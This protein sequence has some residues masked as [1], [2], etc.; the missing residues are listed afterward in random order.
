M[1]KEEELFQLSEKLEKILHSL[2]FDRFRYILICNAIPGEHRDNS[3]LGFLA[4]VPWTAV[5]D[6]DSN[7]ET[8]GM[9]DLMLRNSSCE[10]GVTGGVFSKQVSLHNVEDF[11]NQSNIRNM[12]YSNCGTCWI[13]ANGRKDVSLAQ[14]TFS[15]WVANCKKPAE[16]ALYA[17]MHVQTPLVSVYLLLS[18][19]SLQELASLLQFNFSILGLR[20]SRKGIALICEDGAIVQELRALARVDIGEC[21]VAGMSWTCVKDSIRQMLMGRNLF[22]LSTEKHVVSSSGSPVTVPLG[23]MR[24]WEDINVVGYYEC[25]GEAENAFAEMERSRDNFYKGE[26]PE[27]LNFYLRHDIDRYLLRKLKEEVQQ[28]LESLKGQTLGQ[29]RENKTSIRTVVL[30]HSPGTGGTTLC[31]RV[32]WEFR[33]TFRCALIK[34]ITN[35]TAMQVSSLYDCK[36]S[37][38]GPNAILP[39]LLLVDCVDVLS[40][41]SFCSDLNRSRVRSV[42]L[43]CRPTLYEPPRKKRIYGDAE[44]R[45]DCHLSKSEIKQVANLINQLEPDRDKGTQIIRNV[46]S[47]KQILYFGLQL[48]GQEYNRKL[49]EKYVVYH[50]ENVAELEVEMLKFCSLVYTYMHVGIPRPC[51]QSL[52]SSFEG[53]FRVSMADISDTT[54]DMIV[55]NTEGYETYG[56]E[57]YRPAHHLIGVEVLHRFSLFDTAMQFLD[58]MVG[59]HSEFANVEILTSIAIRLFTKRDTK[60]GWDEENVDGDEDIAAENASEHAGLVQL[61]RFSPLITTLMKDEG[62]FEALELLLVLCQKTLQR[63]GNAF[64][65]QHLAR[66]LAYEVGEMELPRKFA[67]FLSSLLSGETCWSHSASDDDDSNFEMSI[68]KYTGYEAAVMAINKAIDQDK[69]RSTFHTTKGLVYKLQLSP[70]KARRCSVER[71]YEVIRTAQ[72]SLEAFEVAKNCPMSFINWYTMIGKIEVCLDLLAIVK[73][74]EV[75]DNCVSLADHKKVFREF[76]DRLDTPKEMRSLDPDQIAFIRGREE[77]IRSTLDDIFECEHLHLTARWDK[78]QRYA[79]QKKSAQARGAILRR[80]FVEVS[81]CQYAIYLAK[82]ERKMEASPE[83]RRQMVDEMLYTQGEDPYST[84]VGFTDKDMSEIVRWLKPSCSLQEGRLNTDTETTV[85]MFVRACVEGRDSSTLNVGTNELIAIVNSW[86]SSK[87]KSAWAHLFQY[88]LYFPLPN[89]ICPPNKEVVK[90]AINCCLTTIRNKQYAPRKSRPRYFVGRGEGIA[91]IMPASR[92]SLE[93][94]ENT[95]NFWRSKRVM[96]SL[97]RLKGTKHKFGQIMYQ[98]IEVSFD[99]ELY[100]KESKDWLWFYLGFTIQGPYAYDPVDQEKYDELRQVDLSTLPDIPPRPSSPKPHRSLRN[101]NRR[102]QKGTTEH[103]QR[104]ETLPRVRSVT[105]DHDEKVPSLIPTAELPN[106]EVWKPANSSQPFRNSV[107][108]EKSFSKSDNIEAIP[109]YDISDRDKHAAENL[110]DFDA[111]DEQHR[112]QQRTFESDDCLEKRSI[113]RSVGEGEGKVKERSK[114]F[115]KPVAEVVKHA[116]A[117]TFDKKDKDLLDTEVFVSLIDPSISS[118]RSKAVPESL[119]TQHRYQEFDQLSQQKVIISVRG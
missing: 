44:Y 54:A 28:R 63:S 3:E 51:V 93:Y 113:Y 56:Y 38:T 66:F 91:M 94:Y 67:C 37:H 7:S 42:I 12:F 60:V 92:I 111:T 49:L 17:C 19:S 85:L 35:S 70:Y 61:R 71:L 87:P 104:A 14:E 4:E 102:D 53:P 47:N 78:M 95:T 99:N 119:D 88:M 27:W 80:K 69:D 81:D 98:G 1:L 11:E 57:G 118:R 82:K 33:K 79:Y 89:P 103:S 105:T 59:R 23:S 110:R 40:F 65:W 75:F 115:S 16:D 31:R 116:H 109:N 108:E 77:C 9:Y 86:C 73:G 21:C 26:Q 64:V 62:K 96:A 83:L 15:D 25:E 13:F 43:Q 18:T 68:E 29:G 8:G 6:F 90:Q 24:A 50:L 74:S 117:S 32:L 58:K 45:L 22:D 97:I 36:E 76:M 112:L 46:Q 41:R 106:Q 5:I 30:H 107:K 48:F 2:D 72:Q 20:Q 84:W 52:L 10:G 101:P 114:L 39:V 55:L 34:A 100:P